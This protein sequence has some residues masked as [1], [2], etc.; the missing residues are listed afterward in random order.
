[1]F[2]DSLWKSV[3]ADIFLHSDIGGR[4]ENE[5]KCEVFKVRKNEY[6]LVLA[7]GLG[8]HGG[9]RKASKAAV[10]SVLRQL[11]KSGIDSPQEFD[12]W[13]QEANQA[14]NAL[15]SSEC[16]MKTTLVVLYI[17][18]HTAMWAHIGDS[19]LYHFVSGK[20]A[21]KTFD[22]SVSQMAVI[23]GEIEESDIRGHVDRNKLLR[24]LGK[25]DKV[26][27]DV[28][29]KINLKGKQH[30]FLLCTDGFW[31]YI[32]ENE[33]EEALEQATCAEEWMENMLAYIHK[34]TKEGNDNNTAIAVI[35]NK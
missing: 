20:I 29:E 6:C 7:D 24:A 25:E 35:V 18:N 28:S 12:A 27:I 34:R 15:Q 5:D 10:G 17:K 26:K 23:R 2:G 8:G 32:Y 14:V 9:G 3:T 21:E 11:K 16:Q 13:F 30:A 1:M 31:E 22:H 19:R 4:L 33:M